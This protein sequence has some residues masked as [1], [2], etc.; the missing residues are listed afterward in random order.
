[1]CF[2]YQAV[3]VKHCVSNAVGVDD[4]DGD[5]KYD[6]DKHVGDDDDDDDDDVVADVAGD[7]GDG[8]DDDDGD[9]GDDE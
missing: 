5:D 3:C 4:G 6:E 2:L 7:D 9:D 1:M 8:D